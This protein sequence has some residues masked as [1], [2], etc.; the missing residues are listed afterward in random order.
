VAPSKVSAC[1]RK[2]GFKSDINIESVECDSNEVEFE[3]LSSVLATKI[4]NFDKY[5]YRNCDDLIPSGEIYSD[6]LVA[7]EPSEPTEESEQEQPDLQADV[8]SKQKAIEYL[9]R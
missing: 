8:I 3:Q 6:D 1:F 5:A 2:G 4:V 9:N 7:L